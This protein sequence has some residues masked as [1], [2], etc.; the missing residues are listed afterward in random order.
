MHVDD[1]PTD[2]AP[3]ALNWPETLRITIS[4]PE[5]AADRAIAAAEAAERDEQPPAEI[6]FASANDLRRLLTDRRFEIIRSLMD[7]PAN[8]ISALAERLERN[9]SVVYEDLEVLADYG[10]VQ[11][12]SDT[13]DR[14][15]FVP[16]R[17]V[18]VDV[19]IRGTQSDDT[20]ATA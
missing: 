1:L 18:E 9:Y 15:P 19:T 13:R 10:I 14:A 4:T 12:R 5:E 6:S 2:A 3:E 20:E 16:Y 11:F 17:S 8:S 7:E